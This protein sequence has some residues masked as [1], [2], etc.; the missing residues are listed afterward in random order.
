[1]AAPRAYAYHWLPADKLLTVN[2][3]EYIHGDVS[4]DD[5]WDRQE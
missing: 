5:P 2:R 4:G 1:M 3:K